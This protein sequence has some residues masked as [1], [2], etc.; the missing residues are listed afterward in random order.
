MDCIVM[1]WIEAM[2]HFVDRF[3]PHPE[4]DNNFT[5]FLYYLFCHH[6]FCDSCPPS[7]DDLY[8]A[9]GLQNNGD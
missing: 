6:Y 3:P 2:V 1:V 9:P 5:Q 8:T 4:C 7:Y